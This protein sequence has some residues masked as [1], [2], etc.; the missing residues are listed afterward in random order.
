MTEQE[1]AQLR[2]QN[3]VLQQQNEA[4]R[5]AA[6][7]RAAEAIRQENVVFAETMASEARIPVA[8]KDQVAAIG[9]QLQSASDAEFGEGDAKK[10]MYQVFRELIQALPSAVEFG[11]TATRHR[12]ANG[13]D[14]SSDAPAFAESATPDR[15]EQDKRIRAYAKEHGVTYAAAAHAVMRAK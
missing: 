12:A 13:V 11:E 8:L 15:M 14:D 2:E 5:R 1:A 6:H 4:L 9:A 3:A 7:E 10:P